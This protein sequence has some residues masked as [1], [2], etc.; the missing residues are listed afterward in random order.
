M[1]IKDANQ[2]IHICL[3]GIQEIALK[4]L[5]Q[6]NVNPQTDNF[7]NAVD[8]AMKEAAQIYVQAHNYFK[9]NNKECMDIIAKRIEA[10]NDNLRII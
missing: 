2:A 1:L 4:I 9:E 3:M 6:D 8:K 7:A 5:Q 10:Q